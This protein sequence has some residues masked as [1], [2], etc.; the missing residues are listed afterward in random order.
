MADRKSFLLRIDSELYA[1]VAR[2]ADDEMRSLNGQIEF[3]LRRALDGEQRLAASASPRPAASKPASRKPSSVHS[4]QRLSTA[5]SPRSAPPPTSAPPHAAPSQPA[6]R[7]LP[8]ETPST[9]IP[10]DSWDAMVD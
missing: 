5:G 7:H 8:R 1:A 10:V 3:L 9:R 6:P 2:W 4:R